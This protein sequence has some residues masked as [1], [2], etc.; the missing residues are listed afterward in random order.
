MSRQINPNVEIRIIAAARKLWHT[1]GEEAL[2]MRAIA[3]AARTNTPAVYR[4]FRDREEILRALVASYQA[5]I[6]REVEPA[7]SI[8]DLLNRVLQFGL[9][10]PREYKLMSSG[11]LARVTKE[12][13]NVDR[14]ILRIS[15]WLGGT[16]DDN[17]AL[18]MALWSLMHGL[19]MLKISGTMRE[20][21]YPAALAAFHKAVGVLVE[22][23]A[24]LNG[25]QKIEFG[26][27]ETI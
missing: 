27:Y 23:R 3:R 19:I 21:E 2:S 1:G 4:R 12:R 22:N 26:A 5:E 20:E 13:P 8:P 6:F 17:L 25:G 16:P 10:Q 18:A 24:K 15:S 11:L 14:A 9:R 7:T